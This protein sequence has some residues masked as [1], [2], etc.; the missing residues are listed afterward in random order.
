M[1]NND[2]IAIPRGRDR[3]DWEIEFGTVIG[4]PSRD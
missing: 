2:A 3:I 1:G 4:R